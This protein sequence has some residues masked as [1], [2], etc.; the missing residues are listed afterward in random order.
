MAG[1]RFCLE[2]AMAII[3]SKSIAGYRRR[4]R[5][6]AAAQ[7]ERR[8]SPDDPPPAQEGRS[9]TPQ[10]TDARAA[11]SAGVPHALARGG[12]AGSAAGP[13]PDGQ[14]AKVVETVSR[15]PA[16]GGP[17]GRAGFSSCRDRGPRVAE[18][19]QRRRG[20]GRHRPGGPRG[21]DV[22][23]PGAERRGQDHDG[24][25]PGRIPAPHRRGSLRPGCRP[26]PGGPGLA[27]AHRRGLAGVPA[28]GR[29][30]R[31]G[32]PVAV[33]RVLPAGRGR[34][35]RRWSWSAW[36]ITA[37]PGAAGCPAASAGGWMW[38]WP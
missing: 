9:G 12:P 31:R 6:A 21:R 5:A 1:S 22:R 29:A 16:A 4:R 15:E 2:A 19:L 14:A 3:I 25:D 32:V 36:P 7:G 8:L 26:G 24:G 34:W 10:P 18:V 17:E 37:P 20:G 23:V 35:P 38:P 27:G 28:G 30:D 33:R 11:A 13:R